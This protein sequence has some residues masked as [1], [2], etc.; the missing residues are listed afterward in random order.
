M[1]GSLRWSRVIYEYSARINPNKNHLYTI[2]LICAGFMCEDKNS[3]KSSEAYTLLD[4]DIFKIKY[5]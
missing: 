4:T 3:N 5:N 2:I 1:P